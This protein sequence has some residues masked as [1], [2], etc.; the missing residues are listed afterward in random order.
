MHSLGANKVQLA[1]DFILN[2]Q[3]ISFC[4]K[5]F[6]FR[7]NEILRK[8]FCKFLLKRFIVDLI[9]EICFFI[10]FLNKYENIKIYRFF[11]DFV[12][13]LKKI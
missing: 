9:Y 1:N 6:F 5:I 10:S 3:C 13:C 2:K 11:I 7:T 12:L 4:S 8:I